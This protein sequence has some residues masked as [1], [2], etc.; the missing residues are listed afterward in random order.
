MSLPGASKWYVGAALASVLVLIAGWF[1]LVSPQR[2]SAAEIGTAADDR[3]AAN[4]VTE[5]QIESLKAQ[6]KNLP[7]LEQQLASI[8]SRIPSSP[9]MPSVVRSVSTKAATAGVTL[10]SLVPSTPQPLDAGGSGDQADLAAPG[11]VNQY[12]VS[13]I[14][15]GRFANVRLFLLSLESLQRSFLV[16]GID[17]SR[18]EDAT[19]P[20]G[21]LNV[22]LTGRVFTANPGAPVTAKAPAPAAGE[23][24]SDTAS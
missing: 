10:V 12:P 17:I 4:V 9:N 24:A 19:K 1:L 16:T 22:T 2:S 13:V 21:T 5:R 18:V 7:E 11:Q 3:A 14:V 23:T 15:E 6:Y 20:S 8:R